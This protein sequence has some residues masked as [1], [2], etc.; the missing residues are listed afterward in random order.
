MLNLTDWIRPISGRDRTLTGAFALAYAATAIVFSLWYLYTSG[1][2]LVSTESNRGLYLML[3]SVLVF[4]LFPALP[5]SPK[6]RPSLVD[7]VWVAAA[8]I[9]V[10]YWIDQYVEY[11]VNRVSD[12]NAWDFWM[13]VTAIAVMLETSRRVLG[14][15]VVVIA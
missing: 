10:G 7:L 14:I 9:S 6:T 3:T 2:G 13:G 5:T 4:L 12:P 1:F 15:T 11:A 8:V